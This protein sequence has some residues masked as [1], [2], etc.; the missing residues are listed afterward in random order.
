MAAQGTLQDV[1]EKDLQRS[2]HLLVLPVLQLR[3]S[4]DLAEMV[5]HVIDSVGV[6]LLAGSFQEMLGSDHVPAVVLRVDFPGVK[7]GEEG[8]PELAGSWRLRRL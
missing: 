7:D 1:A 8:I 2:D 6:R 4:A 5:L 3:V